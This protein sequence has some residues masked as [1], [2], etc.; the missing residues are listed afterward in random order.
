MIAERSE[1]AAAAESLT[2]RGQ[3][4]SNLRVSLVTA[5]ADPQRSAR[6]PTRR[7]D[8][9]RSQILA[10]ALALCALGSTPAFAAHPPASEPTT[11]E[12]ELGA[13]AAG[14]DRGGSPQIAGTELSA[15]AADH[16][17][18]RRLSVEE[19]VATRDPRPGLDH[20]LGDAGATFMVWLAEVLRPYL[21]EGGLVERLIGSGVPILLGVLL[22]IVLILV[23]R[24]FLRRTPAGRREVA[25]VERR[26]AAE[27]R[28]EHDPEAE[29]RTA[30]E[31]GDVAAALEALWW[32]LAM[33]LGASGA[34]PA[35]TTR[36]LVMRAGRRDLL[37][38]IRP[39][40]RLV[41]G[42]GEATMVEVRQLHASLER[43]AG[44]GRS[45]LPSPGAPA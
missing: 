23:I 34:D 15:T 5:P 7:A 31:S 42:G 14:A 12:A 10:A 6:R 11:P 22:L 9:A 17:L 1:W 13:E 30:F 43:A 4:A 28:D 36:E 40:D 45:P 16:E 38:A 18:L 8:H 26:A 3:A 41:Y 35:W 39:F 32:W 29:L 25:A 44:E 24:R 2:R 20:Y 27:R 21:E 33:A 19:N 37:P